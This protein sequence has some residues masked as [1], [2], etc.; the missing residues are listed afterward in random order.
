V[1]IRRVRFGIVRRGMAAKG[2]EKGGGLERV[3]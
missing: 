1:V 3:L 2:P